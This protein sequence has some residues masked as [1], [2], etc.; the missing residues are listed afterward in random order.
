M[1]LVRDDKLDRVEVESCDPK[2]VVV[3]QERDWLSQLSLT[4][5]NIRI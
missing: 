4:T 5:S 1:D 2:V 3:D